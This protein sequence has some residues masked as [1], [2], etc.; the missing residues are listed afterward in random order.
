M[1]AADALLLIR[2]ESPQWATTYSGKIFEYMA[3][4]RPILLVGPQG[5]ASWL[6]A[7]SGTG[8]RL[9]LERPDEATAMCRLLAED[10]DSFWAQY[11]HPDPQVVARYERR[12]LTGRLA[13]LFDD[14][15]G[16]K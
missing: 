2:G 7:E 10:P 15:V 16:R 3:A 5:D 4:G 9:P 14:L 11:Y 13:G 8:V 6:L 12:A 1:Q